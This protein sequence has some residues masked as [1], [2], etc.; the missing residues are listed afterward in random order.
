MTLN[1]LDL[2]PKEL[3]RLTG[4]EL[5]PEGACKDD[6]C[7]PLP[8]LQT[9]A[10]GRV[11]VAVIAEHLGMPIARDEAHSLFALGPPSGNRRVLDSARMPR[12]V[13][14]DFDG[15]TFDIASCRGR[16]VVLLAW[17]SW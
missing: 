17:A 12:L 14:P 2:T 6:V 4:W 15:N 9:D 11:D 8:P 16:K 13:L 10:D 3:E 1:R 7:V 5:K